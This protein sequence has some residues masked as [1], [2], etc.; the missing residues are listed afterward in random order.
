MVA[1]QLAWASPVPEG[2]RTNRATRGSRRMFLVCWAISEIRTIGVPSAASAKGASDPKGNPSISGSAA[3]VQ[4]VAVVVDN[5]H[6]RTWVAGSIAWGDLTRIPGLRRHQAQGGPPALAIL[7]SV[8][9]VLAMAAGEP[10]AGCMAHV[11]LPAVASA[12]HRRVGRATAAASPGRAVRWGFLGRLLAS[13]SH[14]Q[15]GQHDE[16]ELEG[17]HEASPSVDQE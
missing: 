1:R 6:C 4:R 14:E 17:P 2:S 13:D 16:G 10:G 3:S 7:G 15:Q 9:R 8:Q 5:S 12:D 11:R